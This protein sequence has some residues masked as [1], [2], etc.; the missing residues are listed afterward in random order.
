MSTQKEADIC[1]ALCTLLNITIH[2]GFNHIVAKRC[3]EG[4]L[5]CPVLGPSLNPTQPPLP[6]GTTIKDP[7]PPLMEESPE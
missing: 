3:R 6:A 5:G 2:F 1:K 7:P 4:A